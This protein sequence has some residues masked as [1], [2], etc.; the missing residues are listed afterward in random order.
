MCVCVYRM[1]ISPQYASS[2]DRNNIISVIMTICP[3][4]EECPHQLSNAF[5]ITQSETIQFL[6]LIKI[7]AFYVL[8]SYSI[9]SLH[10]LSHIMWKNDSFFKHKKIISE[11]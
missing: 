8:E 5:P 11:A 9:C 7:S 2:A 4:I 3:I 1:C 10:S 6:H